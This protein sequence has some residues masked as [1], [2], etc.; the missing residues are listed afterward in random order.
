MS[1]LT[2]PSAVAA[3]TGQAMS[4]SV[5]P[6]RSVKTLDDSRF[7]YSCHVLAQPVDASHPTGLGGVGV[8]ISGDNFPLKGAVTRVQKWQ[9]SSLINIL[10]KVGLSRADVTL[11]RCST[12]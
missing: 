5:R 2:I 3:V 11:R 6:F 1:G 4:L 10:R 7:S 9:Y 8:C 12:R